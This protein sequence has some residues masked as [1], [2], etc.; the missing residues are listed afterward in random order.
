[1]RATQ[2]EISKDALISN[3]AAIKRRLD[4]KGSAKI[5]AV[6]KANAY[7]C[8]VDIISNVL[9]EEGIRHFAV[10]TAEEGI[11]LKTLYP[12]CQIFVMG[13]LLLQEMTLAVNAGCQINIHSIETLEFARSIAVNNQSAI[14]AHLTFDT[15]MG[16][17]G[18]QPEEALNFI[19][20]VSKSTSIEVVAVYSHLSSSENDSIRTKEQVS[21]FNNI[22]EICKKF[23]KADFKVHI[24]NSGGLF[25]NSDLQYDFVRIGLALYGISS[26]NQILIP[27]LIPAVRLK[28]KIVSVKRIKKGKTISYNC[29][30]I[31]PEDGYIGVIPIGYGDGFLRTLSNKGKVLINDKIYSIVGLICMDQLMVNLEEDQYSIGQDVFLFGKNDLKEL[32]CNEVAKIAQ[33]T[34]HEVIALLNSR[35][36]R[37]LVDNFSLPFINSNK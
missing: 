32:N 18:V 12:D 26:N 34:P 15:G 20:Q 2:L 3:L 21:C 11:H 37:I 8:G 1:M 35:V 29:T 27:D 9:Y 23:L 5:H 31:M 30:Y 10:I 17:L 19:E 7:G 6:V 25:Y 33:T 16:R 24:A 36:R 28:S 14:Q 13:G 22:L 4:C